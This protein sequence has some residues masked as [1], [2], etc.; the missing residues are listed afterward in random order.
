VARPNDTIFIDEWMREDLQCWLV[1][2][3]DFNGISYFRPLEI[4]DVNTLNMCADASFI[5]FGAT[6]KSHWI[7]STYPDSWKKL[8]ITFLE[9]YPLFV[10]LEIFSHVFANRCIR[11][12]CDNMAVVH[13]LNNQTSRCSNIMRV[14]RKLVILLANN[15]I[16]IK[17]FHIPGSLNVLCDALSRFK[18]CNSLLS[19]YGMDACPSEIPHMLLPKN[20]ML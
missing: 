6:F 15:N 9:L 2:L 11:I 3:S 18:N 1:F 13:I 10:I 19:Q 8:G 17:A 16:Y 5:G 7:Q 4:L 12:N 20:F 14:V